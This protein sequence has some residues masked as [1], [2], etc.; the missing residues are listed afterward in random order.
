MGTVLGISIAESADQ[1]DPD[2]HAYLLMKHTPAAIATI[3]TEQG[4]VVF[5]QHN[6]RM[7]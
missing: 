5:A 7:E 4:A 1:K 2:K 3:P 6:Q